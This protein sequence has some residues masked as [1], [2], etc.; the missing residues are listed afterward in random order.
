MNC[1]DHIEAYLNGE[2]SGDDLGAFEEALRSDTALQLA[3]KRHQTAIA[4][5]HALRLRGKIREN[6]VPPTAS[7]ATGPSFAGW[8]RAAAAVVTVVAVATYFMYIRKE[9]TLMA[10]KPD[11]EDTPARGDTDTGT[12]VS[13]ADIP[14]KEPEN[15]TGGIRKKNIALYR[16]TVG[17]IS[18]ISYTYLE[19]QGQKDNQ[20][21]AKLNDIID[22]LRNNRPEKAIQL[23]EEL[24]DN[25][26]LQ[27]AYRDD[28]EWLLSVAL[29]TED[30][31]KSREILEKIT[32]NPAHSCRVKA[33]RLLE[34]LEKD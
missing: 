20:P 1:Y 11:R 22:L 33:V 24:L 12:A 13:P 34:K 23:L 19:G 9:T 3:V 7:G 10:D 25:R 28:A 4:Q 32:G 5:L 21:E 16:E 18:N 31:E 17:T 6:I 27:E 8:L 30:E 29:I 15:G 26:G 2:L 14:Q